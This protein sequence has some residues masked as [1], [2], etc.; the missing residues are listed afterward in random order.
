MDDYYD[1]PSAADVEAD[2]MH[3]AAVERQQVELGAGVAA[4]AE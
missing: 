3:D 1:L 2:V 4:T